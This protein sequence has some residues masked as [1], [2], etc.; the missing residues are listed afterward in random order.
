MP[1]AGKGVGPTAYITLPA[2]KLRARDSRAA[3]HWPRIPMAGEIQHGRVCT[4]EPAA[5]ANSR[6]QSSSCGKR[7]LCS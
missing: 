3:E 6:A 5:L 4:C 1:P 2:L 7:F